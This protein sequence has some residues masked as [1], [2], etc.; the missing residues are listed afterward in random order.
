M[1]GHNTI[2]PIEDW[3]H[4][5]QVTFSMA[6]QK[7]SS[8]TIKVNLFNVVPFEKVHWCGDW[9]DRKEW[10]L[11]HCWCWVV[12]S[13]MLFTWNWKGGLSPNSHYHTCPLP[14]PLSQFPTQIPNM[15]SRFFTKIFVF[16]T[17]FQCKRT[18]TYF[19]NKNILFNMVV[20]AT[21]FCL[22]SQFYFLSIHCINNCS[23]KYYLKNA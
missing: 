2:V 7:L 18:K 10:S 22:Q 11:I 8:T 14:S 17:I 5:R 19:P 21:N 20:F 23:L 13:R 9:Y 6:W 15:V 4:G 12:G 3:N 16:E 1:G